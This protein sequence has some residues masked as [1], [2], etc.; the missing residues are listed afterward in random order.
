MSKARTGRAVFIDKDGTLLE[1]V[2]Y[3]IHPAKVHLRPG[4]GPALAKLCEAGFELALVTNQ[5]G[6]AM[7]LFSPV[8]LEAV[9]QRIHELLAPHGAALAGIYFCPHHP[10]GRDLR[11]AARCHCRKPE[12]G[13]LQQAARERG[14][15]LNASWMVG[16]ILDDVEAGRRAGCRTVLIAPGGETEWRDG[17]LRRPHYRAANLEKAAAFIVQN[18]KGNPLPLFQQSWSGDQPWMPW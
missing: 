16:D 1:N 17:P 15:D 14:Y 8:A 5:P 4:A 11:Y 2:P 12:P 13:M 10:E 7:G 3:N 6:V 18:A 9:W